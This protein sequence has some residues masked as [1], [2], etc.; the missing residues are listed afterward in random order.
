M[1]VYMATGPA[2]VV[3]LDTLYYSLYGRILWSPAGPS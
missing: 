1:V 3:L 2:G